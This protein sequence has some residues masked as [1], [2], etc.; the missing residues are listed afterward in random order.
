[1]DLNMPVMDGEQAFYAIQ[2]ICEKEG[3]AM[4]SVVFC[5]GYTPSEGVRTIVAN[6]RAHCLLNK[7]VSFDVLLQAL[8]SRLPDLS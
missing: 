8:K 2:D 6:N 5:T 3:W 7:P 1:M 4:P